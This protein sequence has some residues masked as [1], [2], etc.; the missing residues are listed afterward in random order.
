MWV[1]WLVVIL[2][3]AMVVGP[4]MMVRPSRSANKLADIR[5]LA[6]QAGITVRTLSPKTGQGSQR[7]AVY[8]MPLRG[9][10]REVPQW[11][12]E[13]KSFSH[14]AHFRG[15]WDWIGDGRADPST[16]MALRDI[17]DA[18][19]PC[20]S[21]MECNPAGVGV[22]WDER[23]ADGQEKDSVAAVIALLGTVASAVGQPASQ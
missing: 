6:N 18:I 22:G 7:G 11:Q 14:D 4:V 19:A 12:L 3:V 2:V 10:F 15:V 5:L 9:R 20:Y 1:T 23:C 8:S 16:E 21:S 13:R 17:I